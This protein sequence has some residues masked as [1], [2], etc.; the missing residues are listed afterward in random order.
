[1]IKEL[2]ELIANKSY[3][4]NFCSDGVVSI[5]DLQ[6]IIDKYENCVTVDKEYIWGLY[7]FKRTFKTL[8]NKLGEVK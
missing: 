2:E 4:L 3:I 8:I 7:K 6:A 5:S 1:M